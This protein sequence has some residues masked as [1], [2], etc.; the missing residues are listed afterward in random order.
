[1][2]ELVCENLKPFISAVVQLGCK[3]AEFVKTELKITNQLKCG[4]KIYDPNLSTKHISALADYINYDTIIDIKTTNN[5]TIDY[6]KQV[7]A[8]HYLSTKRTD[9]DI[10]KVIVF[11]AVTGRCVRI[12][13]K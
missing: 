10:K 3:T 4:D 9:L 12:N 6:V 1:M 2:D 11:D 7:L 5:I 13:I 8:Y